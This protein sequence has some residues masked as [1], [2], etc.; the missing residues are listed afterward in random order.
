MNIVVKHNQTLLDVA[1]ILYGGIDNVVALARANNLT[2]IASIAAGTELIAPNIDTLTVAQKYY[3]EKAQI[4]PATFYEAPA[5]IPSGA[6]I[7]NSDASFEKQLTNGEQFV[8]PDI[9][10]TDS[11]GVTTQVP[12]V[13]DIV[14]TPQVPG[15]G[16]QRIADWLPIDHLV[17]VGDD[18]IVGLYAI[19]P[20][21]SVESSGNTL[22]MIF[23]VNVTVNWGD[24]LVDNYLANTSIEHIFDFTSIDIATETT[25][26]FRQSIITITPTTGNLNG[27]VQIG[28]SSTATVHV[29]WLD[30]LVSSEFIT[31][32]NLSS[33]FTALR[34]N[35]FKWLGS[36][37]NGLI[38]YSFRYAP[39][40][41]FSIDY[42]NLS[43]L[44]FLL[45][46]GS[47]LDD[48]GDVTTNA[49]VTG[50]FMGGSYARRLGNFSAPNATTAAY[51]FNGTLIEEIGNINLAS[52][53]AINGI[54]QGS[55][56]L[57]KIGTITA[58]NATT[59]Y[60][61]ITTISLLSAINIIT[62]VALTDC[63]YAFY[64]CS[65]VPEIILSDASGITVTTSMF[66]ACY[67]LSSLRMPEMKV[68]FSVANCNLPA[69]SLNTLFGDLADLTGLTAQTIT[70]TGNPGA[71]TCDQT[72][73]TNK[74]WIVAS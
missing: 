25:E 1:M 52:A 23:P 15:T 27:Y 44:Q 69:T 66:Y 29:N 4:S 43:T 3:L 47:A 54:F 53:T 35:I 49:T 26:G 16:W 17:S 40:H 55:S 72:I 31:G 39:L 19:F 70:I 9:N 8:L 73:A 2:V 45:Y 7:E 65:N 59:L 68:S 34:L 56:L 12:S 10:F 32:F 74:N 21:D 62:S 67:N 33:S 22:K 60:F 20:N 58:P 36:T 37:Y 5:P 71:A 11:T 24:G 13:K 57:K 42:T 41:I 14:A 51:A 48:M 30:I 50:Y 61:G 18:K 63:G 38:L 6:H 46:I 28:T 64:G